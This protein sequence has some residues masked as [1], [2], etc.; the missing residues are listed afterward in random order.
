M[1]LN[2]M[3]KRKHFKSQK[4]DYKNNNMQI[5]IRGLLNVL[6]IKNMIIK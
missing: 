6:N 2:Q 5:I 1:L 4:K 3:L